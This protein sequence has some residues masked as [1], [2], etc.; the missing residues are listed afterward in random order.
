METYTIAENQFS[1]L[2]KQFTGIQWLEADYSKSNG[3]VVS[4]D[5]N[6][7]TALLE[8]YTPSV[9]FYKNLYEELNL[10]L[11]DDF[12]EAFEEEW[13]VRMSHPSNRYFCEYKASAKESLR[14]DFNTQSEWLKK[15]P[16]YR[17]EDEVLFRNHATSISL[18]FINQGVVFTS[19]IV[20]PDF[21]VWKSWQANAFQFPMDARIIEM[22]ATKKAKE[23]VQAKLS[24]FEFNTRNELSFLNL[25][26]QSQRKSYVDTFLLSLKNENPDAIELYPPIKSTLYTLAENIYQLRMNE[27]KSNH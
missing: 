8:I 25:R 3:S 1:K 26:S 10:W 14:Q 9:V 7:F 21:E 18:F 17:E 5:I 20:D 16:V 13:A 2:K 15:Y 11:T 19:F 22:N 27:N 4:C 23:W 12:D 24:E 6:V